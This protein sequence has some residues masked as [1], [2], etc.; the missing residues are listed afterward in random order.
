MYRSSI[1]QSNDILQLNGNMA[2]DQLM[3][4]SHSNDS[5]SDLVSIFTLW[6]WN[7]GI[8]SRDVFMHV[9]S[10]NPNLMPNVLSM[11]PRWKDLR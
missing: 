11:G 7:N 8:I 2:L 10:E 6:C 9:A 3:V 1:R 4:Y 5:V